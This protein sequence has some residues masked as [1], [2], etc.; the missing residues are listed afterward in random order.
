MN[1]SDIKNI[2]MNNII[3][4]GICIFTVIYII[5]NYN[6]VVNGSITNVDLFNSVLITLVIIL[7]LY[8]LFDYENEDTN[9][10]VIPKFRLNNGDTR[11]K[12][13]NNVEGGKLNINKTDIDNL[14]NTNIFISQK[15]IGKYG[16]KF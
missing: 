14:E 11:Y 9:D 8:I 2:I 16:L 10:I 3:L 12:I 13:V 6:K 5:I 4:V 7:I 1:N 15:N